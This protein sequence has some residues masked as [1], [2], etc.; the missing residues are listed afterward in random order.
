MQS[1]IRQLKDQ[2]K[3]IVIIAHR[4]STVINA[5]KIVVL[6]EGKLLEEGTHFDL[7]LKKGKYF[8]M[9]QKQIPETIKEQ[10]I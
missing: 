3:T 6:D 10:L 1:A 4:L 2:G 5:D 7:Y 8:K 9:W